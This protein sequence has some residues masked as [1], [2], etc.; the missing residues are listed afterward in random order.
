MIPF[1]DL[2]KEYRLL[3][4]EVAPVVQRVLASGRYILGPEVEEF[5]ER[6][7]RYCEV[8]H[9]VFVASGTDALTLALEATGVIQPGA[10][11]EVITAAHESLYTSLAIIRA[12]GRPVF[13][14]IDAETWLLSPAS[15]ERAL[16]P[17][18]RAILPVHL[19]G[20]PCDLTGILELA[21]KHRLA[22]VE[23]ACQAHGARFW[24]DRWR[25]VGSF[26]DA[27]AFSFYPTKNLGCFGD[28]G[29][30]I[31]SDAK[32][33]ERARLLRSGGQRTRDHA[34]VPGHNSRGDEFQAAI[35][36]CKLAHL[37]EW[38]ERRRSLAAVYAQRLR[39][40]GLR[41]QAVPE[42]REHVFH[43]FVI[44]YSRRERLRAYLRSKA[45][46]TMIHYPVSLH[47]QP[48][49]S[50]CPQAWVPEAERAAEEVLSLPLRPTLSEVEVEEVA[51]A[52]NEFADGNA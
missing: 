32:L 50:D 11:D 39:L 20:L 10:G 21:R 24:T 46:E 38:N 22:V 26:G 33:I 4:A 15:V 14:D 41:W 13:A 7:S 2:Q 42:G 27:A 16:T 23:D 29:I 25:R 35:L 37:D 48:A 3:E 28:A 12:G 43:L 18:T 6:W 44:R 45:I 17:R 36:N 5:E 19:Y 30:I 34:I 51:D 8:P 52:V 1:L 31:S 9:A 40:P 49:F 47:Q